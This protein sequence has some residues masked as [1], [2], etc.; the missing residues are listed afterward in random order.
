MF[1]AMPAF[2]V[3][4]RWQVPGAC[5]Q[6]VQRSAQQSRLRR[7]QLMSGRVACST[8]AVSRR[9]LPGSHRRHLPVVR[10]DS[11]SLA[12]DERLTIYNDDYDGDEKDESYQHEDP[13]LAHEMHWIGSTTPNLARDMDPRLQKVWPHQY[14]PK[15]VQV[16]L[17]L[18]FYRFP[19]LWPIWDQLFNWHLGRAKCPTDIISQRKQEGYNVQDRIVFFMWPLIKLYLLFLL[20]RHVGGW[21][22]RCATHLLFRYMARSG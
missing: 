19:F 6:S 20:G 17:L 8:P 7:P 9:R 21:I 18:P 22:V 3:Q 5:A 2:G 15:I 14:L 11:D 1:T 10:V 13:V 16:W 12:E 4:S